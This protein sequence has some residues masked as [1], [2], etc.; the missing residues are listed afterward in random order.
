MTPLTTLINKYLKINELSRNDLAHAVGYENITKGLRVID[1]FTQHLIIKNEIDK[2]LLTALN[3]PDAEYKAAALALNQLLLNKE[4]DEFKPFI[5]II[6]SSKPSPLFLG[7]FYSYVNL[8]ENLTQLTFEEE[9]ASVVN[10]YRLDQ[11]KKFIQEGDYDIHGH[12]K[13][14]IEEL[15]EK[16]KTLDTSLSWAVGNG[17]HYFRKFDDT[18]T[19][20]ALGNIV[21]RNNKPPQ[22]NSNMMING[23]SPPLSIF[24]K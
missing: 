8:P 13:M 20:D 1:D 7:S 14:T 21:N 17:F 11:I 22:V 23:Q 15:Y 9:I 24:I 6:L 10:A 4:K 2:K 18:I 3:I 16:A 12:Y 5:Q 19:F